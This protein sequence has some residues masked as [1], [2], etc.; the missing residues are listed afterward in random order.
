VGNCELQNVLL[1]RN[2]KLHRSRSIQ[3]VNHLR[4]LNF[5]ASKV[6]YLNAVLM[7]QYT[8]TREIFNIWMKYLYTWFKFYL[9]KTSIYIR[10]SN[11]SGFCCRKKCNLQNKSRPKQYGCGELRNS[12]S[13]KVLQGFGRGGRSVSYPPSYFQCQGTFTN[14]SPCQV[15]YMSCLRHC[16][17]PQKPFCIYNTCIHL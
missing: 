4:N 17:W 9:R 13:R 12:A 11:R 16:S 7:C 8:V 5:W 15:S 10:G 2:S 14:H 3:F 6:D 1:T